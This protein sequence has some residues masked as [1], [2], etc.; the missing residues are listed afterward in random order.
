MGIACVFL[1][2]IAVNALV[3]TGSIP[4]T[5][6]P[7]PLIS[8]GN[9]QIIVFMASFGLVSGISTRNSRIY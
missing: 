4:P 5:G 6:L 9:T 3:V 8:S 1:V 2:Q 7:F